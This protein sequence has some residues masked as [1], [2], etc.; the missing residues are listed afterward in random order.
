MTVRDEYRERSFKAEAAAREKFTS[1]VAA[2]LVV[3]VWDL[4]AAQDW[5]YLRP[6]LAE[7]LAAPISARVP[8]ADFQKVADRLASYSAHAYKDGDKDR[9]MAY[10]ESAVQVKTV[11]GEVLRGVS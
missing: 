6:L 11:I 2:Q 1:H 5:T 4:Y 8:V 7:L 9:A 10:A 3:R